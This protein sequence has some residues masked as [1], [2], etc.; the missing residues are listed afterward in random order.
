MWKKKQKET[1]QREQKQKETNSALYRIM[2]LFV[3][4]FVVL[5]GYLS[6]FLIVESRDVINNPYNVRQD[7]F[8]KKVIRGKILGNK[9][10]VLA[11]TLITE[12]GMES[13]FYPYNQLFA[14]VV[15]YSQSG[16]TGLEQLANFSLLTSDVPVYE[17]VFNEFMEQKHEGNQ[18][19]TTLDVELQQT[20]Y[21]AMGSFEGA[22]VVMEPS[23]GKILAMVSRPDFNPNNIVELWDSLTASDSTE[24]VLLNRAAQGLYPPGSTFKLLTALQYIRENPDNYGDFL[25]RCD[26]IFSLDNAD[27]RCYH[28]K[29]HGE[30][31]LTTAFAKSCNGA[32][33]SI[34]ADLDITGFRNLC[35]QFLFNSDLPV[36]FNYNKSSYVLTEDA[37]VWEVLQ[38]AIGQGKTEITPI[39]NALIVSA[40]ANGGILMNPYLVTRVEN[41]YGQPVKNYMPSAY[42]QLMTAEEAKILTE[43]MTAAVTDGTASALSSGLYTAAGK[44]GT[45]EWDEK[46]ESHSWFIGFAPA[47]NPKL[48]VSIILEEAGTGSEY[49]VPIAKKIFDEYFSR[50]S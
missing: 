10:E 25:Y 37:P 43:L 32:F 16:K 6:Y 27:I 44:T 22:V 31:D 7:N 34:G 28:G 41:A 47:E 38:S 1:K 24:S 33:A 3:G 4:L 18:V 14:H 26:G 8:S 35:Q 23:T 5:A 40:V 12:D 13:R 19:V 20:A 2:Y 42:G 15:G 36:A 30:V 17:K 46:R 9:G 29:S 45:A 11:E 21:D 50:E 48:A 39:H 49:A